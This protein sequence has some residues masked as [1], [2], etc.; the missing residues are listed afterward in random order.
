MF[1]L[2]IY[3]PNQS[4]VGRRKKKICNVR[5]PKM[6]LLTRKWGEGEGKGKRGGGKSVCSD[7][8]YSFQAE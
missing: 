1:G 7:I 6:E 3:D 2:A 8:S 5:T 4:D